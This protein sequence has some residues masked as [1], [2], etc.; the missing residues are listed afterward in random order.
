MIFNQLASNQG[1]RDEKPN[2]ELAKAICKSEDAE[3]IRFLISFLSEKSKAVQND[4]IKVL[5][6]IGAEKPGLIANYLEEFV[7]LL[8]HKNNRLQWGGMAAIDSLVTFKANEVYSYIPQILE[9]AEKGSV[10]TR[11]GAVN[12][13]IKLSEFTDFKK[14]TLP[15]LLEQLLSCPT[16]QLPMYA[17]RSIGVFNGSSKPAFLD[18]LSSR[19]PELVKESK[20]KRIEKVISKLV[21]SDE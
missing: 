15:L 21:K 8:K 18:V 13:L 3:A 17:E 19:L 10:I 5:Y 4:S 20:R 11:D 14:N 6:E 7:E 12:I 16:N 9:A 2:Q 1:R